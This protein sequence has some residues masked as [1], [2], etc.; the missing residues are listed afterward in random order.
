MVLTIPNV[1]VDSY[2]EYQVFLHDKIKILHDAEMGYRRIAHW[3]PERGYKTASGKRFFT[4]LVFS[5]LK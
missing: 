3:L 4:N 2:L 1:R 5:V